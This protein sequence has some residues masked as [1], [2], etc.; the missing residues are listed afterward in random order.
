MDI[1]GLSM[2]MAQTKVQAE[3]GMKVLSMGLHSAKER[4][5]ELAKLMQSASVITNS[6]LGQN[7]NVMA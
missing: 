5:A 6:N 7:V 1:A 3:A 4:G 2:N